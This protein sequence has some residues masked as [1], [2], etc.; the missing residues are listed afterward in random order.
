MVAGGATSQEALLASGPLLQDIVAASQEYGIALDSNTESLVAQ[1][2]E[3]GVAFP[4]DP[5]N[6]MVDLLEII[7]R[8]LG[9]DLPAATQAAGSAFEDTLGESAAGVGEQMQST[10]DQTASVIED[11]FAN[12]ADAA[13]DAI[14]PLPGEFDLMGRGI[15][16]SMDAAVDGMAEAFDAMA[17]EAETG[18]DAVADFISDLNEL[19]VT[20]PVNYEANGDIPNGWNPNP[21][22]QSEPE[23]AASGFDAILRSDKLF[24]GHANERVTIMPVGGA[25]PNGMPQTSNAERGGGFG[26]GGGPSIVYS[27]TIIVNGAGNDAEIRRAVDEALRDNL[28]GLQTRVR[29]AAV[30]A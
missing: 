23:R 5:M 24:K 20:I 7:A 14:A 12:A 21:G 25:N 9:A 27:P 6:R 26:F 19:E 2:R 11:G 22:G 13:I 3:A 15:L 18:A 17:A 28:D 8:Q 10:F 29:E 1:A 4:E 16:S 30:A